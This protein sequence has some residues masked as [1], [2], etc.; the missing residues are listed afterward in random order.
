MEDFERPL[1]RHG[2]GQA[3]SV[4]KHLKEV[5]LVPDALISSS[6]LR[7]Q[8]TTE[9][10]MQACGYEGAVDYRDELYVTEPSVYVNI[11][12]QLS[13][14]VSLPMFVGHNPVLEDLVRMICGAHVPLSSSTLAIITFAVGSWRDVEGSGAGAL[15]EVWSP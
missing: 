5:G 12:S 1:N 8:E 2:R 7:A 13:D 4:G 6:A 9:R 10:V 15:E 14:D 3:S 11:I